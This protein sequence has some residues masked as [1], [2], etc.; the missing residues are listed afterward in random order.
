MLEKRN[1]DG[2]LSLLKVFLKKPLEKLLEELTP[3]DLYHLATGARNSA[4]N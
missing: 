2:A 4:V 1:L 3:V